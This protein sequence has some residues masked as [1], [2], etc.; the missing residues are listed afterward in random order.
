MNEWDEEE[1]IATHATITRTG[2]DILGVT[3]AVMIAFVLYFVL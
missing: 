1:S 2:L 3:G